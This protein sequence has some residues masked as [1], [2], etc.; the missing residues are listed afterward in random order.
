FG[1]CEPLRHLLTD[2]CQFDILHRGPGRGPNAIRSVETPR[3]HHAARR[4]GGG[5]RV[6]QPNDNISIMTLEIERKFLVAN[7]GWKNSVV[8]SVRIRDGLIANNKGNKARVRIANDVATIALK[9]RRSGLARAEFEYVIPYSDAEEMLRIMC[10]G[11]V[12]DKARHFVSHAGNTWQVDV[13]EG[14][15][16]GIVLAEIELTDADQKLILPDWIGAEVTGDPRYRK[17]NMVAAA[18]A[19]NPS[20]LDNEAPIALADGV[21][22]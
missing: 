5:M 15:L 4:G 13:Y 22:E 2:H 14:L 3:V 7:D 10:E 1:C 12:L 19:T 9:S 17:I 20:S 16:E 21:I 6:A 18:R 8:R 11:N